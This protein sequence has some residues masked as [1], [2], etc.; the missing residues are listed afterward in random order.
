MAKI[1]SGCTATQNPRRFRA[2]RSI[3]TA[4]KPI[5]MKQVLAETTAIAKL[6]LA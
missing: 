1:S 2:Q 5:A 6:G 4:D 3:T